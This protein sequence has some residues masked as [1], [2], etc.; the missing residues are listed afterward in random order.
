MRKMEIIPAIDVI[1]GKCVRLSQG[2]YNKKIIY[3]DD[4]LQIAKDFEEIGIKRL[5]LVDLEG[6]KA[7][8]IINDRV[9]EKISKHTNLIVDFGGGVK[10]EDDFKKAF[11]CGASMVTGGSIAIKNKELFSK[12][13]NKYG[14]DKI[15]LGADVKGNKIAINGWLKET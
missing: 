5:H 10:S 9:L 13:I 6:A 15:I 2:N 8:K 1:D 7:N 12:M 11:A 14:K 4:P 3:N